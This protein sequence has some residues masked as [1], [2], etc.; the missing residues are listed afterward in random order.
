MAKRTTWATTYDPEI[1]P[2]LDAAVPSAFA[3]D[4]KSGKFVE[5]DAPPDPVPD[6]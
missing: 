2:F 3:R 4:S 6:R 1:I 5:V